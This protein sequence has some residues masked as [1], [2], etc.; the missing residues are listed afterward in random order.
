MSKKKKGEKEK[1]NKTG[2]ERKTWG[3]K[4]SSTVS[5]LLTGLASRFKYNVINPDYLQWAN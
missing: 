1:K 4:V 2:L 5:C 3:N